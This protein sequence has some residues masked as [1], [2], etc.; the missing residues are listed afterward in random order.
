MTPQVF[1]QINVSYRIKLK[2][3]DSLSLQILDFI[4]VVLR[5]LCP[6]ASTSLN[7]DDDLDY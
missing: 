4:V 6:R 5:R 1:P 3:V 7:I 2:M